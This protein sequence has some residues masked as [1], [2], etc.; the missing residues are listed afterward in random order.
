MSQCSDSLKLIPFPV[1]MWH[2]ELVPG[3][4]P[5]LH[6]M[7]SFSAS[8]DS[9]SS[10]KVMRLSL[11]RSS[12]GV[13]DRPGDAEGVATGVG[14]RLLRRMDWGVKAENT[15]PDTAKARA[16]WEDKHT[17]E[18]VR[19]KKVQKASGLTWDM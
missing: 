12:G 8:G 1:L 13:T 18:E 9:A 15:G 17:E 7:A 19:V 3:L 2:S 14:R 10:M 16:R 6:R 4:T 5:L 11:V